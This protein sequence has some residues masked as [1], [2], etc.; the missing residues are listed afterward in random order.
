M[1]AALFKSIAQCSDPTFRKVLGRSLLISIVIFIAVWVGSWFG[2]SWVGDLLS[3]WVAANST[4]WL[5]TIAEWLFGAVAFSGILVG[6]FL[7]FPAVI[8]LALSF[9]LEEIARAV[10]GRHYPNLPVA[11]DQPVMEAAKDAIKLAIITIL[12][13]LVVLPLY[14]IPFVNLF[15]FFMVNGYLLGREYFELVAV[16]RL[17]PEDADALRKSH[18]RRLFWAGVLIAFLFTIPI[19]NLITP[20]VATAFMVHVFE[21]LRQN[22][23][24]AGK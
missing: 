9:M 5:G 23:K 6:S 13:N 7:I 8:G 14:F 15:V 21:L 17:A 18:G 1:L 3:E 12:V 2:L 19:V 22:R 20:I 11:R 16:R 10:E 4:S 24:A